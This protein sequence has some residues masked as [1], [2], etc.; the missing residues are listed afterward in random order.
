MLAIR[1]VRDPAL[2]SGVEEIPEYHHGQNNGQRQHR[3][4][5]EGNASD[6]LHFLAG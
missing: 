2:I 3:K 1:P 5:P 4:G 6:L